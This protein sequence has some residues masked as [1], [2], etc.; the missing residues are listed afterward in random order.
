MSA[1]REFEYFKN[2]VFVSEIK[3]RCDNRNILF[4]YFDQHQKTQ[5]WKLLL[6]E[7]QVKFEFIKGSENITADY[8]PRLSAIKVKMSFEDKLLEKIELEP[9]T[10]KEKKNYTEKEI[11]ECVRIITC[12]ILVTKQKTQQRV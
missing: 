7:Y 8:M 9:L 6:C 4:N 5:R 1:I 11:K 10:E 3:I 12:Y 2:I